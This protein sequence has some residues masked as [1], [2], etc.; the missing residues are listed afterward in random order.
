MSKGI[1]RHSLESV[2]FYLSGSQKRKAAWMFILLLFTSFLDVIGLASL[3][4]IMMVAAE[5]NGVQKNRFFAAI[6]QGL[7]F[8]SEQKFLLALIIS[9]FFFFLFKNAFATWVTYLQARFTAD[10]GLGIIK[11]QIDKYLHFPYWNFNNLGSSN[12]INSALSVPQSY[13]SMV[14]Q[15]LFSLFSEMAVMLVI[16]ISII[17]YKPLL[18]MLLATVLVPSAVLTYRF[19]RS[20]SQRIGLQVNKLR[21]KSYGLISDLFSGFIELKLAH[22]QYRFR[23][24]LLE[25]ERELQLLGAEGFLYSL[26]PLKVIEMVAILGVLTI[27][28]YA[29][30]VPGTS[31]NLITLIG[32]FA[33]A[34]YRMMPSV[35][36]MLTSLMYI[37]QSQSSIENLEE[38]REPHY[39]EMPPPHQLPL[40][41]NHTLAFDHLCFS[42]PG[43]ES[44]PTL[45][46]ISL[47]IKKGEKIGFIG[48]SGSGKTTL[49]NVLLRFYIEQTGSILID[50]QPLT[51]QHL[52]DWHRIVGY[53]KQDTFL[54][55]ASIQDNITLGDSK[56]D[57]ARLDYAIEQASLQTFVNGLPQGVHTYIGE[58]G[59][60]LSGGQRQRIGIARALYK[61]TEVLVLDE[62]TSALD[63][64]TEREVN[65]A[66]NKLSGTEITILIIAHRITTLRGCDRIYELGLGE[67]IAE[68]QYDSLIQ[69]II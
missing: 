8:Q 52:V 67:V 53:V 46:N 31:T 25:N 13:V 60:K 6:Y 11:S 51:A 48:S 14:I 3:V 47:T 17:L 15:Q 61:R 58:R 2:N 38:Y 44:H 16:V 39:N 10:I 33:A 62:A 63:N 43:E 64:E 29:I 57:R 55:E 34:A 30:F 24:R 54:M 26:L 4:P 27:F 50:G 1:I 7:H 12:L 45:K 59:S 41:F 5:P 23:D 22:K 49:M 36:R 68:H 32:L 18:L 56:I 20:R 66:I 28:F 40:R 35:N 9:V 37:K 65:E 42:F 69:S 19:L 21:P